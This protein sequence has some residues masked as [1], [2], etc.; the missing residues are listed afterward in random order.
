MS[1]QSYK[2]VILG[3]ACVGKSLLLSQFINSNKGFNTLY[4]P[5][6]GL[7]LQIQK[8][9]YQENVNV[10]ASFWDNSG[11]Q[12][13]RSIVSNYL[14]LA[15]GVV[16]VYDVNNKDS[17]KS[18][19]GWLEEVYKRNVLNR[20]TIQFVVIGN[21]IDEMESW[22]E[23]QIKKTQ[24]KAKRWA[25]E[26]G[27]LYYDTSA[28]TRIN[29]DEAFTTLVELVYKSDLDKSKKLQ[30]LE[31]REKKEAQERAKQQ[32]RM[33]SFASYGVM[34]RLFQS[35]NKSGEQN[36]LITSNTTTVASQQ[37]HSTNNTNTEKT[38]TSTS[39]RPWNWFSCK[40]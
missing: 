38:T 9:V 8:M 36:N 19:Q 24:T 30:E 18:L 10:T 7:D 22:N 32:T 31:E 17:F 29:V 23:E 1:H 2:I 28:K 5:T 25:Q 6:L 35:D 4:T 11:Q 33:N 20:E 15:A 16:L 3:D 12:K 14:H 40:S 21:R 39:F 26:K 34:R 27:F 37:T 13:F